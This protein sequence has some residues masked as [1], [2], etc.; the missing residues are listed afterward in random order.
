LICYLWKLWLIDAVKNKANK[1]ITGQTHPGYIVKDVGGNKVGINGITSDVV[2]QQAAVFNTGFRFT[3]GYK[4]LPVNIAAAKSAGARLTSCCRN[5]NSPRTFSWSRN[6]PR[7]TSCSAITRTKVAPDNFAHPTGT[8][9]RY[10]AKHVIDI[11]IDGLGRV[12][13]V[14]GIPVFEYGGPG[15][16]QP[17][18]GA[19]PDWLM[20]VI[21]IF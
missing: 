11:S 3:M 15:I 4:E 7:S 17:T 6:S 9:R 21:S 18:Q 13:A 16:V 14:T 2:P 8:L 1:T 5:W 19:G 20:R 12:T 10:L